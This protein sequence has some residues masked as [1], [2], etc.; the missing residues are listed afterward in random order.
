MST[1]SVLVRVGEMVQ[2]NQHDKVSQCSREGTAEEEEHPRQGGWQDEGHEY[3]QEDVDNVWEFI[4]EEEDNNPEYDQDS[5]DDGDEYYSDYDDYNQIVG[6]LDYIPQG[7]VDYSVEIW[8]R[9]FPFLLLCFSF[10]F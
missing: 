1:R 6:A 2:V 9:I 10:S 3:G 8:S 4:V 7:K 5:D